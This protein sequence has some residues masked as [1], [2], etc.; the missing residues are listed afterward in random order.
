MEAESF[1]IEAFVLE[2][3]QDRVSL[4][5][6]QPSSAKD[7]G[8]HDVTDGFVWT[9]PRLNVCV[10]E[11]AEKL[12][13]LVEQGRVEEVKE[14]LFANQGVIDINWPN[15]QQLNRTV[16]LLACRNGDGACVKELLA[17]SNISVNQTD[18]LGTT[19]LLQACWS[20]SVSVVR[21]LLKDPRVDASLVGDDECTPLWAAARSGHFE[22]VQWLVACKKDLNFEKRVPWRSDD[23]EGD[24]DIIDDDG[25]C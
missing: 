12:W 19:A 9:H 20:G 1:G 8:E 16:L 23:E 14:L 11:M 24:H 15:P 22:I 25:G 6:S 7:F 21:M 4:K 5:P 2:E 17:D 10:S 3:P 18:K 13:E